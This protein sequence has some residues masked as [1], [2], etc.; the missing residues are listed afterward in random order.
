MT[1]NKG[2]CW[3]LH[4]GQ[5][6]TGGT[7]RL[8]DTTLECSPVERDVGALIDGKLNMSQQCVLVT[9]RANHVLKCI[10]HSIANQLKEVIVP[11]Y[12]ALVWLRLKYFLCSTIY[13]GYKNIR[14]CPK[15]GNK[16]G[17]RTRGHVYEEQLRIS[18]LFS[19]EKRRLRGLLIAVYNFLMRELER[20]VLI[21]SLWSLGK[22][23]LDIRKKFFTE[24]V[25]KHWNKLPREVIMAPSLAVI[26]K[27]LDNALRYTCW[28]LEGRRGRGPVAGPCT[29]RCCPGM[30]Q[31][32]QKEEDRSHRRSFSHFPK[33]TA[34]KSFQTLLHPS[35]SRL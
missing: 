29:Q 2:K 30:H 32:S 11:L 25:V 35:I 27:C 21:S 13:E 18:S 23:R 10:K 9:E 16:D 17:E 6:N 15:E 34:Y 22:F 1:F 26:K 24:R 8:G 14:M 3:I 20:E 5:C 4:L 28:G 19:L 33:I 7:Y 12:S 31:P